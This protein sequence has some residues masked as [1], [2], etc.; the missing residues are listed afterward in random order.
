MSPRPCRRFRITGKVQGVWFRESTRREA[1]RLGLAG[2]AIN[3]ADGSV[4]VVAAGAEA[5]LR[6]LT[7]WLAHGPP[8]ARVD[9]VESEDL[10][11]AGMTGFRTG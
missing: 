1:L 2:H 7:A 8:L 10:P 3:L 5:E 6:A 4:E 9:S 11:D